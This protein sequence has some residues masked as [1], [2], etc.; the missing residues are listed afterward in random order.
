MMSLDI[1]W[2]STC[3][4]TKSKESAIKSMVCDRKEKEKNLFENAGVFE[5]IADQ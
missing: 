2:I 4:A 5:N 3:R 1:G